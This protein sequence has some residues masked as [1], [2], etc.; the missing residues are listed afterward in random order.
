[1]VG[2]AG[3]GRWL[4]LFMVLLLTA[5]SVAAETST[6]QAKME[7]LKEA[8]SFKNTALEVSMIEKQC[9]RLSNGRLSFQ[10][11]SAELGQYSPRTRAIAQQLVAFTN[12]ILTRMETENVQSVTALD[13]T[14]E[15]QHYED[16][17]KFLDEAR[18]TARTRNVQGD[19]SVA[20][21]PHYIC[22][23]FIL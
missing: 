5:S 19:Y 16:L 4:L 8:E 6:P 3:R 22:G 23:S 12:A 10:C 14:D 15:L 2:R 17:K 9:F 1:M 7:S 18:T 11:H 13:M 20:L 21:L